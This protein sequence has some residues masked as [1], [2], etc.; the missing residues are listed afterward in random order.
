MALLTIWIEIEQE[1]RAI[2]ATRG[3]LQFVT[4]FNISRYLTVLM[5][6]KAISQ[7]TAN[8]ILAFYDLRNRIVH[9]R[10]GGTFAESELVALLDSGLRLLEILRSVPRETYKVRAV[11]PFFSDAFATVPVEGARAVVLETTTPDGKRR[12]AAYP[13][14]KT[15]EQGRT[16]SWEWNIDRVWGPAWYRDSETGEI[17]HA[18]D[19]AGEFVGRPL[20]SIA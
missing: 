17:K 6:H 9:G 18:W 10:L 5:Q 4:R 11:V 1:L 7:E 14:T 16:L 15:Y 19:A 20:E 8:S 13:T 3:L 2:V 12:Y